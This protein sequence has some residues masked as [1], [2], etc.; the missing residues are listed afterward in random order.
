MQRDAEKGDERTATL[1]VA[2]SAAGVACPCS[3]CWSRSDRCPRSGV[4]RAGGD[5]RVRRG[6]GGIGGVAAR[7]EDSRRTAAI[8]GLV[9]GVVLIA[10][11]SPSS[12][13]MERAAM[14]S[15]ACVLRAAAMTDSR[16]AMRDGHRPRRPRGDTPTTR[17]SAHASNH[18]SVHDPPRVVELARGARAPTPP[19]CDGIEPTL[20]GTRQ[21]DD[22]TGTD[23]QDVIVGLGG[24][25]TIT[26]LEGERR[27]LRGGRVRLVGGRRLRPRAAATGT[28]RCWASRA[29]T[30]PSARATSTRSSVGRVTTGSSRERAR[31]SSTRA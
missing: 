23:G 22:L 16:H 7:G 20:V 21:P 28:T 15:V 6:R 29:R 3:G 8:L 4:D 10:G 1:S 14:P 13:S 19:L 18:R 12:I 30:A 31:R 9:L 17:R 5:D 27:R 26:A 25:D 11:A 24:D 2:A